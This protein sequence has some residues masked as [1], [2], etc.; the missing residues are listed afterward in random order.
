MIRIVSFI[1]FC[2]LL[3]AC[4]TESASDR[5]QRERYSLKNDAYPD[6]VLDINNIQDAVPQQVVRTKAGNKSPYTVLGKTY[7]VMDNPSGFTQ[8]GNASWYGLKFHGH[9]TSNGETY[10]MYGMT[11]AHKTLPIPTYVRV[12]NVENGLST[13]VRVNDRGPF[14]DDRIIDLSY[15][16][17][18]KLNYTN[19]GTAKVKIEVLDPGQNYQ[20]AEAKNK[21]APVQVEPKRQ[22][23]VAS[24][25]GDFRPNDQNYHLPANT[26]LQVGAFS[27]RQSAEKARHMVQPL[28][29]FPVIIRERSNL[30][31]VHIGPVIDNFELLELRELVTTREL[32]HPVVVYD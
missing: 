26:F 9:A 32:G 31:K 3:G 25:R 23:V 21:P 6:R 20:V 13:V 30:F 29:E 1:L 24:A 19:K 17:A 15:A 11:A 16:A 10:D 7:H 4:S 27:N 22:A 12:T 2:L 18:T 5:Y 28:T 14:H 8:S